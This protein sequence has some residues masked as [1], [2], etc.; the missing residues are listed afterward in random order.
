MPVASIQGGG[1]FAAVVPN[2]LKETLLKILK[3]GRFAVI[4][5]FQ[6]PNSSEPI[7]LDASC[8]TFSEIKASASRPYLVVIPSSPTIQ[9]DGR[10]AA[11]VVV[12]NCPKETH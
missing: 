9:E 3:G 5:I 4:V 12:P 11:L 10:F 1:R 2:S 6:L 7:F 8:T